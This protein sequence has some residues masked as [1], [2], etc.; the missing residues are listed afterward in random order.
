MKIKIINFGPLK[1]FEF[2]L[3]KKFIAIYGNNNIGKSYA[4]QAVYLLLRT[5]AGFGSSYSTQLHGQSY[6]IRGGILIE[7]DVEILEKLV[8]DFIE[9]D[10]S[11]KEVTNEIRK[12]LHGWISKMIMP[13]FMNACGNTFG[14][15]QRLL[16]KNPHIYLECQEY[17]IDIDM[18]KEIVGGD[19]QLLPVRLKKTE[20]NMH[21]SRKCGTH[22]DIYVYHDEIDRPMEV[23][24]D[25]IIELQSKMISIFTW[26]FNQVYFLPASRSGIYSGMNAFGAIVAELSR[27][28]AVLTK[29]IE[30]PGLSEPISDYFI[31]LSNIANLPNAT[32]KNTGGLSDYC[33]KIEDTILNGKVQFD[34][35]KNALIYVPNDLN[36]AFEMTEVSSMVSEVSPIVAFLKYIIGSRRATAR[37]NAILFIEEPEAHLHPANQIKLVEIF[38]EL[39][40]EN[41]TLVMSSHSNYVFNK[42]NNLI[43]SKKLD[44]K[45]YQPVFLE[46]G[47]GGSS[48]KVLPIDE[49]GADD[50]NFM[51]VSEELYQE[52]ET[53]IQNFNLGE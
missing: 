27:N 18:A 24:Y 21:A 34:K 41:V 6:L 23:L 10:M 50:E 37:N 45:I 12:I 19:T 30:L 53:I 48:S 52:R 32:M 17:K 47:D 14:N 26:E 20:S 42:L 28:R 29:K 43:L 16:E 31:S 22:L 15:F 40:S 8:Q 46:Q 5:F 44:Y 49:C 9:G 38:A 3:S 35:G 39:I 51:D 4:M 7:D 13:Y 25:W 33:A 1:E 11:E 2:D 36:T